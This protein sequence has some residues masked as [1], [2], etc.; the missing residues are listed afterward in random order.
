[1]HC[2]TK[3]LL[4]PSGGNLCGNLVGR[5]LSRERNRKR[6]REKEKQRVAPIYLISFNSLNLAIF[7]TIF[8]RIDMGN[9]VAVMT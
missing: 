7:D 3:H 6:R 8:I 1:M 4:F 5:F 2:R 9:F